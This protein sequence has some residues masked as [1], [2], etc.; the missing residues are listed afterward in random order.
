MTT[1]S[2]RRRSAPRALRPGFAA[3]AALVAAAAPAPAQILVPA[4]SAL[5]P[6]QSNSR[7]NYPLMRTASRSQYVVGANEIGTGAVTLNK[8]ALRYDGPSIGAAGGTLGT[9]EIWVS[10][11]TVVPGQSSPVFAQNHGGTPTRVVQAVNH[12]FP[13]DDNANPTDFGGPNGELSFTFAAPFAY[14]GGTLVVDLRARGNSNGGAAPADCLLDAEADPWVGPSGGSAAIFGTGCAGTSLSVDGQLAPGG[15]MTP[16]G[17]GFAPNATLVQTLGS[18][19]ATW[20]GVPLPLSLAPFG[21]PGCSVYN[22]I[23]IQIGARADGAGNLAA[24]TAALALPADGGLN[25]G[26]LQLQVLALQPGSNALGIATTNNVQI[27]LGTWRPLYR[28]Y[29]A[30]F[31]HTDADAAVA[32]LNAPVVLAMRFN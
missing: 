18:S 31:H 20:Q 2:S 3:F 21:A 16:V 15:V 7:T 12:A 24:W 22:D 27:T 25:G 10:N 19:R 30:H 29:A 4:Q 23:A 8:L 26:V 14:T 9:L 28:G 6:V 11:S 32:T 13:V 5:D 1:T 17:T